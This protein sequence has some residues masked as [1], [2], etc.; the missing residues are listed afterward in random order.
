MLFANGAQ[1]SIGWLALASL[2]SGVAGPVP[3]AEDPRDE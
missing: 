1:V 3:V 2:C